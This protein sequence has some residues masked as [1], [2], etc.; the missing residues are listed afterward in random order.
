M[1]EATKKGR[2]EKGQGGGGCICD[3]SPEPRVGPLGGWG[4]FILD[5]PVLTRSW[6]SPE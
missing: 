3:Q 6:T 4:M 1:D 2:E 5:V